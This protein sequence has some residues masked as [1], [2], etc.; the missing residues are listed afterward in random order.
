LLIISAAVAFFCAPAFCEDFLID[1]TYEAALDLPRILFLLKR[2]ANGPPLEYEGNFELNWAFLDTGA[3]G[4][5][6]SP[7]TADALG[8]T[9]EPGALYVDVGVGGYEF[10][11][12]TEPLYLGTLAYDDPNP[13]NPARYLLNPQWRF[14]LG[15][16]YSEWLN[17]PLDLIGMPAMAG[18]VV[19]L[20]PSRV[21]MLE[22]FIADIKSPGDSTIPVADINVALRFEKYVTP[23]DPLNTPPLPVLA[24]NP[25]IVGITI[26]YNADSSTGDWLLDTG[27]TVSL[28]SY[29]QAEA[30]GLM[31][32]NHNPLVPVDFNVPIGG[33]GGQAEL[34][35]FQID[36]LSVPTL[37]GYNIVFQNARICV[38]DIGIIDEYGNEI[39]LDGVFGSNFLCPTMNI[40]TWELADTA[41]DR[42]IINMD[43]G[44]LGF[45]V[46]SEYPLPPDNPLPPFAAGDINRDFSVDFYDLELFADEWLNDCDVLT[47]GCR[48]ADINSDSTVNFEDFAKFDY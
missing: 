6:L 8:I 26:E 10:F 39:I 29:A 15:Q 37:N 9:K 14:Q 3:S 1:G 25:L 34:P 2:D 21:A 4:L 47:F 11:D 24:Y 41:F 23:D 12:V 17:E 31:D 27:G 13:E 32:A 28:F 20:D 36:S 40:S 48:D 30:L 16:T 44:I 33:I 18:K 7:E 22:Y 38:H 5:L 19:V 43:T 46:K 42:I 45:A 35:G